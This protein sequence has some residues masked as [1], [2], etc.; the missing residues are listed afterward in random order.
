MNYTAN[1]QLPQW[2]DTDRIL[3]DDFNDMTEA[4]D[5]TLK[6]NADGHSAETAA[7]AAALAAKGNCQILSGSYVGTGGY[8]AASPTSYTFPSQPLLVLVDDPLTGSIMWVAYGMQYA[9]AQTMQGSQ[10]TVSWAGSTVQWFS[11]TGNTPQLNVA[12][13]TYN[14]YALCSLSE[15]G[16]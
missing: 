7:R 12:G 9:Y 15:A 11:Y 10:L 4:I 13:W 2:V 1:Y 14:V 5:A 8:G 6:T 3:M 16:E